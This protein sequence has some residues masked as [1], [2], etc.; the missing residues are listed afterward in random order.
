MAAILH[1]HLCEKGVNLILKDGVSS[2]KNQ[3]KTVILNSGRT[4]QQTDMIILAI[5]VKPE[6]QLAV[7]AG[8]KVGE[9]GGIKVNEYLQTED[10]SI[11]A[12]GDAIEVTDYINGKP[13]QIPLAWPANRQGRTGGGPYQRPLCEI[14][15]N[16]WYFHCKGI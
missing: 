5:G 11:Y 6:N 3:G 13:T 14:C 16:A 10:P 8:L 9:R 15:R 1:S 12:I 7:G 4:I 2:F